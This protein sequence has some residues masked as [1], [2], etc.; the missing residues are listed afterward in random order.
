MEIIKNNKVIMFLIATIY[1]LIYAICVFSNIDSKEFMTIDEN[2]I[3]SS[4]EQLTSS[5]FYNM[6]D[7]YHSKFYGWTYFSFNFVI[8]NFLK[9]VGLDTELAINLAIRLFNFIIGLS[10]VLLFFKTCNLLIDRFKSALLT[11]FFMVS[12]VTAHFFVEIH[13]EML[14]VLFQ[15]SALYI[16]CGIYLKGKKIDFNFYISVVFLSLSCLS[17][18]AFVIANTFLAI[19]FFILYYTNNRSFDFSDFFKIIA[20]S[21]FIFFLVFF[22]IHPYAF[23]EFDKFIEAQRSISSEHSQKNFS[24][25]IDDWLHVVFNN[26]LVLCNFL[27]IFTLIAW[28]RYHVAY[29]LSVISVFT[30]SLIYIY[31]SRLWVVDTYF[32][33]VYLFYFFNLFYFINTVLNK[34]ILIRVVMLLTLFSI[35]IS[36]ASVSLYKQ[37]KRFF[38]QNARTEK[39][40][41]DILKS[42]PDEVK[43]AY[44]PNIAMPKILRKKG[45]HA[46]QGCNTEVELSKYSPDLVVY[47]PTYPHFNSDAFEKYLNNNDFVLINKVEPKI[48]GLEFKCSSINYTNTYL[49]VFSYKYI[50]NNVIGCLS[51]YIKMIKN[52]KSTD[53]LVGHEILFYEKG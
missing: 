1:F 40:S 5:A 52:Y 45:C 12:P 6:N 49:Y 36:D 3:I 29:K 34:F 26:P 44:S 30:V 35:F 17:K 22:I 53:L 25:V 4:L 32:F 13:P 31:N 16:L 24:L 43:V 20:K 15:L 9:L 41:W 48:K 11:L 23:F 46:W 14:G 21:L 38:L 18:Q 33:P 19:V 37:Q 27:L 42:L 39:V 51:D 7:T 2:S 50:Y 10:V 47:S 8:I 28:N